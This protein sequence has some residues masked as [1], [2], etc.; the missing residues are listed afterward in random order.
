MLAFATLVVLILD[1]NKP[2]K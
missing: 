1:F 2:K